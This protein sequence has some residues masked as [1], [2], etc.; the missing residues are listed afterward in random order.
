MGSSFVAVVSTVYFGSMPTD[1]YAQLTETIE[2]LLSEP[3][4]GTALARVC[5]LLQDRLP[6]YDWVGF[7]IAIPEQRMLALGPFEGEPTDHL[8]IPYGRGVCGQSAEREESVLVQDVRN[9]SNYLAC[10]LRTRSEL[11]VPVVHEGMYVGQIDIDSH[12][13]A[14]FS[15]V[16]VQLLG[17]LADAV[18]EKVFELSSSLRSSN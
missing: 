15:E 4:A 9:E 3:D 11:V 2:T 7:Y 8:R 17:R 12:T 14:A 18:S 10:S 16:D 6:H 5:R 1:N 13:V